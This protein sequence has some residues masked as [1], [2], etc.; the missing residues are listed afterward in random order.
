MPNYNFIYIPGICSQLGRKRQFVE[1]LFR[2]KKLTYY[3]IGG[4]KCVKQEDLE[5]YVESER[6]AAAGTKNTIK[7]Q[8]PK[9]AREARA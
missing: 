8:P 7:R 9:W 3:T 1:T 6:V 2:S 4:R 5:A